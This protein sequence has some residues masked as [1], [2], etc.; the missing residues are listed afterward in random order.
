MEKVNTSDF[1]TPARHL[2]RKRDMKLQSKYVRADTA[3]RPYAELLATNAKVGFQPKL[4]AIQSTHY[5][6]Y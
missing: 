6:K 3:V 5:T 2:P 1:G 4:L